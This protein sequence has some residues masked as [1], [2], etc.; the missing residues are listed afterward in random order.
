MM[1]DDRIVRQAAIFKV[2]DGVLL[3]GATASSLRS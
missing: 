2:V 1:N 3:P